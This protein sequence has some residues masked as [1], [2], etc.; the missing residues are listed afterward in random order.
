M[1]SPLDDAR[2]KLRRAELHTETLRADIRDVGQGE[3]YTIP[4]REDLDENT[5]ILYLRVDRDTARPEKW[6]LLLGDAIHNFRCALDHGWWQLARQHR[7]PTEQEAKQIQ[8]P[9][10]RKWDSGNYSGTVGKVAAKLTGELQPDPQ[11]YPPDT[12]HPLAILRDLSNVDKHR[13]IHTAVQMLRQLDLRISGESAEPGELGESGLFGTLHHFGDRAPKAGDK[14]LTAPPDSTLHHPKVKFE[15]HQTGFVAIEGGWDVL[16]VL[17]GID[18]WVSH[19]L[20]GFEGIL[21]GTPPAKVVTKQ[22]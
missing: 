22:V 7:E 10:P 8:F 2:A 19:V 11:G 4:L 20:L 9:I 21:A 14:V 17:D 5:G 12:F 18:E 13:N 16:R 3:P 6:G 1:S 15:A